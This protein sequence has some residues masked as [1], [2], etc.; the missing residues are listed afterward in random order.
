MV[1]KPQF[2]RAWDFSKNGFAR[3]EENGKYG[4]INESGEMVIEPQF[5]DAKNFSDYGVAPV[6]VDGKWGTIDESGEVVVEPKFDDMLAF[7]IDGLAYVQVDGKWG[8]INKTGKVIVAPRFDHGYGIDIA[9]NY[10]IKVENG[11]KYGYI[12]ITGEMVIAPQFEQ[13]SEF[14]V[15]RKENID[16]R[17]EEAYAHAEKVM[18]EAKHSGDYQMLFAAAE[19]YD[20][21]GD[22]RDS[23]SKSVECKQ[24]GENEHARQ[25]YQKELHRQEVRY[26][27][28]L[29]QAKEE[30]EPVK[31]RSL[32]KLFLS[33][34]DFRDSKSLA[35][36]CNKRAEE[37]EEKAEAA[38]EAAR[39]AERA[40]RNAELAKQ[41]K[42]K[43]RIAILVAAIVVVVALMAYVIITQF[44]IPNSLL[45]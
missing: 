19:L 16:R 41:A 39:E 42:R 13:S 21:I 35:E 20:A 3:V 26:D 36:Y 2:D 34:G 5:D 44:V 11:G 18:A 37:E 29:K 9:Q 28:W 45:A 7:R 30:K 31:L 4:Y 10:L 17:N 8:I 40:K 24:L 23:A 6:K 27:G 22:Y 14:V 33:L 25:E 32:G 12:D 38:R 15:V 1:I 43:K